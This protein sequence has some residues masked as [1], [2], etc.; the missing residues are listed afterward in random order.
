[1]EENEENEK[2]LD[3]YEQIASEG[4]QTLMILKGKINEKFQNEEKVKKSEEREREQEEKKRVRKH[5]L[6]KQ[7]IEFEKEMIQ[8]E[9]RKLKITMKESLTLEKLNMEKMKVETEEKI[10]IVNE[11]GN[12][13]KREVK[14]VL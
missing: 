11:T 2:L 8:A 12:D 7:R 1:M 13:Y 14:L 5:E 3:E 9:E 6:E 10:A 4:K